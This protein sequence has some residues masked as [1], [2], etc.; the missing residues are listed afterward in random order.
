MLTC[1]GYWLVDIGCWGVFFLAQRDESHND[2][3]DHK[4]HTDEHRDHSQRKGCLGIIFAV[5]VDICVGY[6]A[7]QRKHGA[8]TQP[9]KPRAAAQ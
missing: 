5:D 9:T 8:K 3:Y 2:W 1:R 6:E 4:N 7:D